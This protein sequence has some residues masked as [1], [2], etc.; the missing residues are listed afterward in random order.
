M[1]ISY[2]KTLFFGYWQ[3]HENTSFRVDLHTLIMLYVFN[4]NLK[5]GS[6]EVIIFLHLPRQSNWKSLE[7]YIYLKNNYLLLLKGQLKQNC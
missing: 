7:K 6:L 1:C 2:D 5:E 3:M 4:F